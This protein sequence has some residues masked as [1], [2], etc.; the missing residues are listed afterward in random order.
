MIRRAR[1]TSWCKVQVRL[2]SK[3]DP[4]L[5]LGD[6]F[7]WY[8]LPIPVAYPTYLPSP[9]EISTLNVRSAVVDVP[10]AD[11]VQP[12][13]LMKAQRP[14]TQKKWDWWQMGG[15]PKIGTPKSLNFNRVWNHYKSILGYPYFWKQPDEFRE[16]EKKKLVFVVTLFIS[17]EISNPPPNRRPQVLSPRGFPD[18][19]V[20]IHVVQMI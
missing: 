15:P 8:L 14:G 6:F 16:V 4:F 9:P 5:I 17:R 11:F 3:F 7:C 19:P 18:A 13:E 2:S 1:T 20:T 12:N 10:Q